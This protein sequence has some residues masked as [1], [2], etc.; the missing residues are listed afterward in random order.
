MSEEDPIDQL[1]S[2]IPPTG[3][4]GGCLDDGVLL[5]YREAR[6]PEDAIDAAEQHL[7]SCAE[8]R[9]LSS[10]LEPVPEALETWA[11]GTLRQGSEPGG[12]ERSEGRRW[13]VI[14]AVAALAAGTI[15]ALLA[16][17]RSTLPEY[18]LSGPL[19][20]VQTLRGEAEE[21]ALFVPRSRFKLVVRPKAPVAEPVSLAVFVADAGR[22][23]R[24]PERGL[25]TGEG[26]TFRYE[27]SA[28]ELFGDQY[29]TRTVHTAVVRGRV[30]PDLEGT[31]EEV[32]EKL[33][34]HRWMTRQI[35]YR[36]RVGEEE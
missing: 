24:A 6:L 12:A 31:E 13:P 19:G 29:G 28:E 35:E 36:A 22:L 14:A 30:A 8:C 5:A 9:A 4:L 1:L 27:L 3:P 7:A 33:P 10:E 21:T 18:E 34:A 2:K 25:T 20:G 15:I 23:R 26:G 11:R 17:P 32:R 16:L